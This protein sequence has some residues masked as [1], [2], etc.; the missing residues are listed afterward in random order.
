MGVRITRGQRLGNNHA[1]RFALAASLALAST[2]AMA[3]S[4]VGWLRRFDDEHAQCVG[5]RR[6]HDLSCDWGR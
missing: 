5:N 6:P 4:T 1:A 2:S 3:D